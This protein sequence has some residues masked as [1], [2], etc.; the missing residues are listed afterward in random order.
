MALSS[1]T[2]RI[3]NLPDEPSPEYG[4]A[5]DAN[6]NVLRTTAFT[7]GT[8]PVG[9]NP[10]ATVNGAATNGVATTFMRS[11]A[12]PALAN[13]FTPSGGTQTVTGRLQVND[14]DVLNGLVEVNVDGSGEPAVPYPFFALNSLNDAGDYTYFLAGAPSGSSGEYGTYVLPIV[15]STSTV[16]LAVLE[17]AQEWTQPQSYLGSQPLVFEGAT[18]DTFETTLAV[19]DPTADRT[20]TLPNASGTV[21]VSATA[22]IA[23]DAAGNI[24]YSG[25]PGTVTSVGLALPT[26]VFDISGSPVTGSGTLTATF[27]NQ[28]ANRVFAG[29]ASG[30]AAAP[31][32]RALVDD[33]IPSTL[34][35]TDLTVTGTLDVQGTLSNTAGSEINIDNNLYLNNAYNVAGVLGLEAQTLDLAS[36]GTFNGPTTFNDEITVNGGMVLASNIDA[37]S[38]NIGTVGTLTTN[39]LVTP[40]SG[41]TPTAGST[42]TATRSFH[43][44]APAAAV[45]LSGATAIANGSDGQRLTFAGTSNTNTVTINDGANTQMAGNVTLG[46]GDTISYVY[47]STLGDWIETSRSNN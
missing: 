31:T 30:A 41:L 13:P 29:P 19:T 32:F 17:L 12:A 8:L 34:T 27:D 14:D 33:D 25:T 10:T 15:P 2:L 45:T 16:Y 18:A 39:V 26:S 22:P 6:G 11:D 36:T 46:L 1:G 9:A 4:L 35:F 24:S 21:A 44:L 20:I 47:S 37:A 7:T 40:G 28:T 43:T 23:L 38:N 5:A 3:D 42:V